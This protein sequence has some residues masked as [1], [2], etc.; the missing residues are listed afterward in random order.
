[1][2]KG[3][4]IDVIEWIPGLQLIPVKNVRQAISVVLGKGERQAEKSPHQV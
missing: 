4:L 3:Q 1:M 2:I